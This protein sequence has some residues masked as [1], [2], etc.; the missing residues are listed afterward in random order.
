MLIKKR[1]PLI[2]LLPELIATFV[3]NASSIKKTEMKSN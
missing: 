3:T 1:K 2:N